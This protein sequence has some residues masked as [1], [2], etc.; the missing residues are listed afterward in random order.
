MENDGNGFVIKCVD[1]DLFTRT[2]MGIT[3][4]PVPDENYLISCFAFRGQENS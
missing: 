1:K 2:A 4:F 3:P